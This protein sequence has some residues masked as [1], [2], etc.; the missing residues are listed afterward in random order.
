MNER[1]PSKNLDYANASGARIAVLVGQDEWSKNSASI[2][3]MESGAQKE[4]RLEKL[5]EEVST[6]LHQ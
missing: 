1:G 3:D 4:V 6:L 5:V 2:R